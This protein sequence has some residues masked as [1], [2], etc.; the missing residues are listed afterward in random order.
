MVPVMPQSAA[1]FC[2]AGTTS[3]KGMVTETPP[4]PSTKSPSVVE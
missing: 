2:R 3:A 1:P 4:A